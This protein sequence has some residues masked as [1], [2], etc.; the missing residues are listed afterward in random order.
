MSRLRKGKKYKGAGFADHFKSAITMKSPLYEVTIAGTSEV[1]KSGAL[2][3]E[4][5]TTE[6]KGAELEKSTAAATVENLSDQDIVP[7]KVGST[8]RMSAREDW[9][10]DNETKQKEA[11]ETAAAEAKAEEDA[12]EAKRYRTEDGE[13]AFE[14]DYEEGSSGKARRKEHRSNKE[15]IRDEF[16]ADKADIKARRKSGEISRKEAKKLKKGEKGEKKGLKKASKTL[17]KRNKQATKAAKK[18]AKRAKKG[19]KGK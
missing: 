3:T 16:K 2:E 9:L 6:E 7:K 1:E 5:P 15:E 4:T 18:K 19:K 11:K 17:K 13:I 12:L 8:N 14:D 10:R